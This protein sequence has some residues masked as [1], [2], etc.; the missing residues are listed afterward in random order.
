MSALLASLRRKPHL[1]SISADYFIDFVQKMITSRERHLPISDV[2]VT[3]AADL[4]GWTFPKGLCMERVYFRGPLKMS[5]CRFGNSVKFRTC[6]FDQSVDFA[7]AV[8]ENGGSFDQSS[9]GVEGV[10]LWHIVVILDGAKINGDL[11]LFDTRV[12]GCVAARRL[13]VAGDISFSASTVE[14][15]SSQ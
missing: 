4:I 8:F 1:L 6:A 5:N 10:N 2:E 9:F 13:V 3:G 12:H 7:N 15:D 14:G 11:R